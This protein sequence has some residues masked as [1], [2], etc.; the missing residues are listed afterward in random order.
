MSPLNIAKKLI[1]E[2]L[3]SLRQKI[4]GNIYNIEIKD[5]MKA[6]KEVEKNLGVS[7]QYFSTLVEES[8][9]D[10]NLY[11][12]DANISP[13]LLAR[14]LNVFSEK[15]IIHDTA[16]RVISK[17]NFNDE[18]VTLMRLGTGFSV[19]RTSATGGV[20]LSPF[21]D[22]LLN[23]PDETYDT[24]VK[25]NPEILSHL[26]RLVNA[27][28]NSLLHQA[29]INGR[30]K[31]VEVLLNTNQFD[32]LVFK[33]TNHAGK[34]SLD[35]ALDKKNLE[36]LTRLCKHVDAKGNTALHYAVEGRK[37]KQIDRLL[38]IAP[39]LITQH[40]HNNRIPSWIALGIHLSDADISYNRLKNIARILDKENF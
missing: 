17:I 4:G 16:F 36:I 35:I 37:A 27:K 33:L 8:N 34:T 31:M 5:H 9:D 20:Q 25:N 18:E 23:L 21:F 13:R 15:G 32:N 30:E 39:D 14:Q 40:N 12:I 24:F 22:W 19:A 7:A 26:P 10:Y 28:G 29:I 1:Q 6:V 3:D 38:E 11:E 2:E